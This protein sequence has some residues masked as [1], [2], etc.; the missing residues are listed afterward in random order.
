LFIARGLEH[1]RARDFFIAGILAGLSHLSRA[2]GVLLLAIAPL[3][4]LVSGF[5]FH[6]SRNTQ[7]AILFL[8]GY[9]FTM[10]P[11]FARNTLTLGA[12]LPSAGTKTCG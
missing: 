6:V 1:T 10:L 8:L 9:L 5:R 7:Y 3:A 12:P 2:D 11:W 4:L